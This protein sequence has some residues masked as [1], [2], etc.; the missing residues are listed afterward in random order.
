MRLSLHF[1]T[2]FSFLTTRNY[3][4]FVCTELSLQKKNNCAIYHH[5]RVFP[6]IVAIA[7]VY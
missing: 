2:T 6:Q 4:S 5:H 7:F 1:M 3:T